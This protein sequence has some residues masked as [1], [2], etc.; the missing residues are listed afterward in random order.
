MRQSGRR[1]SPFRAFAFVFQRSRRLLLLRLKIVGRNRIAR[2][3]HGGCRSK[4][5][6][7][8]RWQDLAVASGVQRL[9]DDGSWNAVGRLTF[10]RKGGVNVVLLLL[11]LLVLLLQCVILSRI[12][13]NGSGHLLRHWPLLLLLLLLLRIRDVSA[14][15]RNGHPQRHLMVLLLLELLHLL[16]LQLLVLQHGRRSVFPCRRD[17]IRGVNRSVGRMG[18]L[19]RLSADGAVY[20]A[21]VHGGRNGRDGRRSLEEVR[22]RSIA[23]CNGRRWVADDHGPDRRPQMLIQITGGTVNVH[24]RCRPRGHFP[25]DWSGRHRSGLRV[26]VGIF[27]KSWKMDRVGHGHHGR[28]AFFSRIQQRLRLDGTLFSIGV[29]RPVDVRL[30]GSFGSRDGR[31]RC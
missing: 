1:T 8:H 27:W 5:L 9:R 15:S 29:R 19:R 22:M 11:L 31:L 6:G 14:R 2:V 4:R 21:G 17:G 26:K 16:L 24:D 12:V 20:A 10:G 18:H 30:S 13:G 28:S 25:P 7:R 3:G 23:Q